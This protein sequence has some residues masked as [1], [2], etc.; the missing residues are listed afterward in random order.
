MIDKKCKYRNCDGELEVVLTPTRQAYGK[1]VCVRCKG[2]NDWVPNPN[3]A[4]RRT[5]TSRTNLKDL[6]LFYEFEEYFCFFCNRTSDQL[7]NAETLTIDH[8]FQLTDGGKDRIKNLQILCTPCHRLKNWMITYVTNHL[9]GGVKIKKEDEKDDKTK[10]EIR[11]QNSAR[12]ES[13]FI[14][15]VRRLGRSRGSTKDY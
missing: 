14:P 11:V 6:R 9:S 7:G 1:Y 15:N 13:T 2:F 4:A 3:K 12:K 10:T 5:N 8:I